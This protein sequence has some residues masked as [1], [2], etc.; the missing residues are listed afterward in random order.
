[1]PQ[2]GTGIFLS[3]RVIISD[4]LTRIIYENLGGRFENKYEFEIIIDSTRNKMYKAYK[5]E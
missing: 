5:F 1:M 2:V 3:D 4:V